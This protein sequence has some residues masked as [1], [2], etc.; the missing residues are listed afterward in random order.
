MFS[1]KSGWSRLSTPFRLR[2]LLVPCIGYSALPCHSLF[3]R[4]TTQARLSA[5][6]NCHSHW[7]ASNTLLPRLPSTAAESEQPKGKT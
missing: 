7:F 6:N 4:Q 5:T 3:D 1:L 2:Y